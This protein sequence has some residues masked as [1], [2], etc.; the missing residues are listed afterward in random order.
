MRCHRSSVRI[1]ECDPLYELL[2]WSFFFFLC[3]VED[4]SVSCTNKLAFLSDLAIL[5]VT[6]HSSMFG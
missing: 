6:N 2:K 5:T 1:D 3:D 4:L